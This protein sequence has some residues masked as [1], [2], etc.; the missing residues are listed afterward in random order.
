VP[1]KGNN[2][3]R[4]DYDRCDIVLPTDL[5]DATAMLDSANTAMKEEQ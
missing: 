5:E 4:A 3:G 2:T 1:Y